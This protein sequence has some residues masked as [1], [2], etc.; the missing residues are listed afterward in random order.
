LKS[1]HQITTKYGMIITKNN[2]LIH[3][4]STHDGYVEWFALLKTLMFCWGVSTAYTFYEDSHLMN[5]VQINKVFS[6][7][8]CQKSQTFQSCKD[9]LFSNLH[10]FWGVNN[11]YSK[12]DVCMCKIIK[13]NYDII[14]KILV[15]FL[16]YVE[17]S[18]QLKHQIPQQMV[19]QSFQKLP[20]RYSIYCS[21]N[22]NKNLQFFWKLSI[23]INL[24][25]WVGTMST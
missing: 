17:L 25:W 16:L 8:P 20:T 21:A 13:E 2:S 6:S 22:D 4:L 11:C 3:I 1:S 5:T 12:I 15:L 23:C 7:W 18:L 14:I 24:I 9:L 19:I 10:N